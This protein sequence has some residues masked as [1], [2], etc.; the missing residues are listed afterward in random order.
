MDPSPV[1]TPSTSARGLSFPRNFVFQEM[2]YTAAAD[3][4][5][6]LGKFGGYTVTFGPFW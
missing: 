2:G 4:A 5:A 1:E 3:W 6:F